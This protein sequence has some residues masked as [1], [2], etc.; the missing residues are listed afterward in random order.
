MREVIVRHSRN[1]DYDPG[2]SLVDSLHQQGL[3]EIRGRHETAPTVIQQ[4]VTHYIE[5]FHSTST[6]A[7]ELMPAEEA[8]AFDAAVEQVVRPYAV[9]STLTMDVAAG[10]TWGRPC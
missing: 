5:Q 3:F 4:S 10:I 8:A 9:N 6:L 2:F 7:R 1:P